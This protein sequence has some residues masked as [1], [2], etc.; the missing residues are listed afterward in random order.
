MYLVLN[1][2]KLGLRFWKALEGQSPQ[3]VAMV[4]ILTK[5]RHSKTLFMSTIN[6][7]GLGTNLITTDCKVTTVNPILFS[8]FLRD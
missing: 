7:F 6:N 5:Y 8:Y 1:I 3:K 2:F 4:D